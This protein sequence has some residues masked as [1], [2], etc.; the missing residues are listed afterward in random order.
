MR[1]KL[2]LL[3]LLLISAITTYANPVPELEEVIEKTMPAIVTITTY[4]H[5]DQN[6]REDSSVEIPKN[7]RHLFEAKEKSEAIDETGTG[8]FISN[9][10]YIITSLHIVN[11]AEKIQVSLYDKRKFSAK[12]VATDGV[13]D[14]AL[15]KIAGENFPA[16]IFE[17][18]KQPKI[19]AWVFVIGTPYGFDFSANVG[20]VS[21][22]DRTFSTGE[23][24]ESIAYIQTSVPI[25]PGH[26]GGPV[27]NLSGKVV[28]VTSHIFTDQPGSIGISFAVPAFYAEKLSKKSGAL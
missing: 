26:S 17:T 11:N 5:L 4:R 19:G 23:G 22:I 10:G 2:T 14:L 25:N 27:V 16:L 20:I 9:K 13:A 1:L 21:A 15:L 28:G 3:F 24:V 6:L 7:L 18:A 12:I 8:F